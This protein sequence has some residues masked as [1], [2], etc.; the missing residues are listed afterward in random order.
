MKRFREKYWKHNFLTLSFKIHHDQTTVLIERLSIQLPFQ[1]PL[2]FLCWG[3]HSYQ[4]HVSPYLRLRVCILP[5]PVLLLTGVVLVC[6]P[7]TSFSFQAL[8]VDGTITARKKKKAINVI[9]KENMSCCSNA[10][11]SC[12]CLFLQW[13]TSFLLSVASKIALICNM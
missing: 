11:F 12:A 5:C 4:I 3:N 1:R 8:N 7:G 6:Q 9:Y 10:G 2:L 13:C